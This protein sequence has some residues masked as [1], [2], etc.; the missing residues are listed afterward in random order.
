MSQKFGEFKS[1]LK[2]PG[3]FESLQ[4]CKDLPTPGFKAV[5]NRYLFVLRK[6]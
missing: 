1:S 3:A 4:P 6:Y 2:K 5:R